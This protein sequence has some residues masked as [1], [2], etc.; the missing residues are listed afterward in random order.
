VRLNFLGSFLDGHSS[1]NTLTTLPLDARYGFV[2][3]NGFEYIYHRGTAGG[4]ANY[5]PM[6][7]SNDMRQTGSGGSAIYA[8][9]SLSSLRKN[10][11][12]TR[13]DDAGTARTADLNGQSLTCTTQLGNLIAEQSRWVYGRPVI[14]ASITDARISNISLMPTT[15]AYMD[16]AYT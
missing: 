10:L 3:N 2:V 16:E 15:D 13:T 14:G 1:L 4:G 6:I 11:L 8:T 9:Y 7:T 5:E 12:V